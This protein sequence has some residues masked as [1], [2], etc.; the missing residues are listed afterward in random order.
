METRLGRDIW[1][2][3]WRLYYTVGTGAAAVAAITQIE[4]EE[5]RR[6]Q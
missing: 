6:G 4:D 5:A 2:R 3:L 1:R